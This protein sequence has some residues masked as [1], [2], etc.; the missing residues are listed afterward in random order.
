MTFEKVHLHPF[1]KPMTSTSVEFQLSFI[2]NML[3]PLHGPIRSI[4]IRLRHSQPDMPLPVLALRSVRIYNDLH[5]PDVVSAF[6]AAKWFTCPVLPEIPPLPVDSEILEAHVNLAACPK[7]TRI[8]R[9]HYFSKTDFRLCD[10]VQVF[11]MRG[12][13]KRGSDCRRDRSFTLTLKLACCVYQSLQ[14]TKSISPLK[15]L[16]SHTLRAT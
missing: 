15:T 8:L 4:F 9:S 10:L 5:G 11:V 6:E 3:E 7:I 14:G 1:S 16:V 13:Q 2:K 12:H